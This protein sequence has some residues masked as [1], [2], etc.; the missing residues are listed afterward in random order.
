MSKKFLRV[1]FFFYFVRKSSGTSI[2]R[3]F[4]LVW[5]HLYPGSRKDIKRPPV[6]TWVNTLLSAHPCIR[7]MLR[8]WTFRAKE[9]R[10]ILRVMQREKEGDKQT[11]KRERERKRFL[12]RECENRPSGYLNQPSHCTAAREAY[13]VT[14]SFKKCL[15]PPNSCE[16]LPFSLLRFL[17]FFLLFFIDMKRFNGE[18]VLRVDVLFCLHRKILDWLYA[19]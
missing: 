15:C 13:S 9:R 1:L 3:E 12:L 16:S 4:S 19:L 5:M 6:S 7:R 17:A 10:G 2:L 8:G 14:G 11:E 18:F